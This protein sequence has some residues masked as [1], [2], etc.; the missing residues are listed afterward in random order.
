MLNKQIKPLSKIF[1]KGKKIQKMCKMLTS[2][3]RN[4]MG[5]M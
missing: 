1:A 2:A 5:T 4:K 3:H